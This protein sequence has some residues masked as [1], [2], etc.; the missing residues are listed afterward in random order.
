MP[1]F[2][3]ESGD[4]GV[5][6]DPNSRFFHLAAVWVPTQH[7]AAELRLAIQGTR[8]RL[9]LNASYEFKFSKTGVHPDRRAAFFD[10]VLQHEFRFAVA[11]IDK[12]DTSA[13]FQDTTDVYRAAGVLL[14]ATLRPIYLHASPPPAGPTKELIVLDDNGDR[15]F[16]AVVGRAF[17]E[18]G[19]R[20]EPPV[21]C[22]GKVKFRD[23]GPEELLQLADMLCGAT[24]A[25]RDGR[26]EWYRRIRDRDVDYRPPK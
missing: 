10:A 25:H 3:D 21:S 16:L 26:E 4:P 15:C 24:V 22:I 1:T 2:L 17:R 18:L 13:G 11:T 23:S 20:C 19:E 12:H 6:G 7:V 5:T 8:T 9:G 14:A